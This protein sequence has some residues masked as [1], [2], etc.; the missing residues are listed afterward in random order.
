MLKGLVTIGLEFRGWKEIPNI[1]FDSAQR[2]GDG[3]KK[4]TGITVYFWNIETKQWVPT[5]TDYL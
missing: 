2:V 5:S 3:I 4:F 1:D